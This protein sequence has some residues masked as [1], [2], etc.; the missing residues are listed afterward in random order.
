MHIHYK[1]QYRIKK[2]SI[3]HQIYLLI[4]YL[5]DRHP[6]PLKDEYT[7][8]FS[9]F[10]IFGL[11]NSSANCSFNI[12]LS[13]TPLPEDLITFYQKIYKPLKQDPFDIRHILDFY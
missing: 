11:C 13:L 7:F 4:V 10:L 6:L 8:G 2:T 12:F 9:N 5:E 1:Y 3:F